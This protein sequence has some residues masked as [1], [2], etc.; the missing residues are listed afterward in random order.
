[1]SS[2]LTKFKK[3]CLTI[4][5]T[6]ILDIGVIFGP[7]IVY[8]VKTNIRLVLLTVQ[9]HDWQTVFLVKRDEIKLQ[10]NAEKN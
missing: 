9:A 7:S 4:F 10:I 1:M 8:G 6:I 5:F 3:I 2:N